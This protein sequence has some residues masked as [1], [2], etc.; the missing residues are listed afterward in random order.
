MKTLLQVHSSSGHKQSLKEVLSDQAVLVKLAD[1]KA[2]SEVKALDSFYSMLQSEP[3][4]AF[5]G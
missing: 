1:T 4:R 2:A 3:N 5:Y